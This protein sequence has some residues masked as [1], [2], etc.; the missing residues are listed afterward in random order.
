[1][2]E[3]LNV[4]VDKP[5]LTTILL[6]GFSALALLVALIGVYGV[7][8]FTSGL[9]AREIAIRIVAG[10]EVGDI[11]WMIIRSILLVSLTC[12]A[13]GIALAVLAMR[14]LSSLLYGVTAFDVYTFAVPLVLLIA[15]SI[16]ACCIPAFRA[17][18]T[19]PA[20]VLRTE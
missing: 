11:V 2:D 14:F 15:T 19:D 17:A 13:L 9:R 4:F 12:A 3:R 6:A 20:K 18:R 8:S 5:R 10:A 1:M 16:L 7:V